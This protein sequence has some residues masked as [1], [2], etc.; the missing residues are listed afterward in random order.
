MTVNNYNDLEKV[1]EKIDRNNAIVRILGEKRDMSF[2]DISFRLEDK[3]PIH[4]TAVY[5]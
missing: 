2:K 4:I 5:C 3:K 1:F